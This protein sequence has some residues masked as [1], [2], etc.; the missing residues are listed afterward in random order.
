MT[1]AW[2]GVFVWLVC[3][4]LTW[5][6]L[7][8]CDSFKRSR[9][10]SCWEWCQ[11]KWFKVYT[12]NPETQSWLVS[13][14]QPPREVLL[15]PAKRISE[16]SWEVCNAPV[17]FAQIFQELCRLESLDQSSLD[18][19]WCVKSLSNDCQSTI[20]SLRSTADAFRFSEQP[21]I[22]TAGLGLETFCSSE[23]AREELQKFDL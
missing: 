19:D 23:T 17:S 20:H 5:S 12:R 22:G 11:C 16:R 3:R 9:L 8:C 6:L 7:M 4:Q 15:Q 14:F 13:R 10:P 18:G 1:T 21:D 2:T